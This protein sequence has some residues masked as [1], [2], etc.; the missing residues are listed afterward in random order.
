MKLPIECMDY[1]VFEGKNGLSLPY[2]IYVP[3][4]NIKKEQPLL[5]F[6]HG[7]GECGNDNTT[8]ISIHNELLIKV[9][10]DKEM[11]EAY[12]IAPQCPKEMKW[13]D[14]LWDKGNYKL[15]DTPQSKP[16]QTVTELMEL[17]CGKYNIDKKRIYVSGLSMGGFGTWDLIMRY[18]DIFA[19]A[20]P[21][22][23]GADPREAERIKHIP[24]RTFHGAFDPVVPAEG[25]IK[26]VE[27]LKRHGAEIQYTELPQEDHNCWRYAYAETDTVEWLFAR[28]KK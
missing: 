18:P 3:E 22:C 21:I 8:H 5:I 7:A 6:L 2:R 23:G 12:I 16:M 4:G 17:I 14:V 20:V 10:N 27:E 26:M 19:A 9:I 15:C 1:E 11:S 24:I 28:K 25:T 13:V